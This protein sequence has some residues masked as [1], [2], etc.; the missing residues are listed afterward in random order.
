[1]DKQS[2]RKNLGVGFIVLFA[3]F[4]INS[5]IARIPLNPDSGLN[6]ACKGWFI[7]SYFLQ[8]GAISYI[9]FNKVCKSTIIAKIGC[10]LYGILLITYIVNQFAYIIS[11][12]SLIYFPNISEYINSL[13]FFAPGLLLLTWGSKLWLPSKIVFSITILFD[14]ILDMIWAKLVVMYRN[15]EYYS[16]DQIEP[17]QNISDTISTVSSLF[18]LTSLVLTIVWLFLKQKTPSSVNSNIDLI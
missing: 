13:V 1:M 17:L 6:S 12:E 7:L 4:L 11:D 5:I 10:C 16:F 8:G 18:L 3:V 14:V 9:S 15:Y 2:L